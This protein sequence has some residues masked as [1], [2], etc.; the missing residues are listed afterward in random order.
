MNLLF[1]K[2]YSF[3]FLRDSS[4]AI[5][6]LWGFNFHTF[7]NNT[8]NTTFLFIFTKTTLMFVKM[9]DLTKK[10][11]KSLA[12]SSCFLTLF[13]VLTKFVVK[14]Q[15]VHLPE[16]ECTPE[17]A[18]CLHL[19]PKTLHHKIH[20]IFKMFNICFISQTLESWMY[21]QTRSWAIDNEYLMVY[22]LLQ[23]A[24]SKCHEC[25]MPWS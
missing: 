19:F 20:I 23:F 24:Y 2:F 25:W 3:V 8:Y 14:T 15:I 21:W 22:Q 13:Y 6:H 7:A 4:I 18:S 17:Q 5:W 11:L 9:F 10:P 12:I 16:H 1:T